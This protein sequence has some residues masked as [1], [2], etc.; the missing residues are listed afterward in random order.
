MN[1]IDSNLVENFN[2][3]KQLKSLKLKGFFFNTSF[4]LKLNTLK[5]LKMEYCENISFE[6]CCL[7]LEKLHLRCCKINAGK[8]L[9]KLPNV[10]ECLFNKEINENDKYYL[11]FDFSS[12]TKLKNFTCSGNNILYFKNYSLEELKVLSSG[13]DS[14]E[15]EKK[16]FEKILSIKTLKTLHYYLNK[17]DNNQIEKLKEIFLV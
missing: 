1:D 12:F 7:N 13:V 8:T 10:E 14:I 15:T 5:I 4:C 11:I 3:F 6:E 2:N 16:I 17:L 9:L